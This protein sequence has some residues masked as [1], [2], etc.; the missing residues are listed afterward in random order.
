MAAPDSPPAPAPDGAAA[1]DPTLAQH[2]ERLGKIEQG[3]DS[4]LAALGRKP[5]GTADTD[6]AAD[7]PVSVADEIARALDKRDA[8]E[9][10]ARD[11]T[12][13]EDRI[14]GIEDKIAGLAEKP[15]EAPV[16]KV[17]SFMKWR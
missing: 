4:I 5:A 16:R 9:K 14:K 1:P 6:H 12:A 15:P 7:P 10:A 11:R 2:E 8:K 17:E 13:G 3:I